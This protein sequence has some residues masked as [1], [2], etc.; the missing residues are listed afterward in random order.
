M[1]EKGIPAGPINK[2]DDV[3]RDAQVDALKLVE[4]VEHPVLGLL[5]QVG[6]PVSMGSMPEGESVRWA[7]PVLGQ[8]T[9]EVL[10]SYGIS[11]KEVDRLIASGVVMQSAVS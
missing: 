8:H 7:P 4:T 6:F 2:M 5:K 3:F 11:E 9:R 10:S 1:I